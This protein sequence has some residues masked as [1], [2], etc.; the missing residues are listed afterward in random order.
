MFRQPTHEKPFYLSRKKK[1]AGAVGNIG[2][3]QLL[4][5]T[6]ALFLSY[7][8]RLSLYSFFAEGSGNQDIFILFEFSGEQRASKP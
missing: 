5:P 7:A 1:V 6:L 2:N 3:L 8:I 4:L